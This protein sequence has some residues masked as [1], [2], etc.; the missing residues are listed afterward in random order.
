MFVCVCIYIK[1]NSSVLHSNTSPRRF[2]IIVS[3]YSVQPFGGE[4]KKEK[5]GNTL[6]RTFIFTSAAPTLRGNLNIHYKDCVRCTYVG[7]CKLGLG[8]SCVGAGANVVTVQLKENMH[9]EKKCF[10]ERI[11]K[12]T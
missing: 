9:V 11:P 6:P 5:K 7:V 1:I 4:T 2:H 3:N 12:Q 10:G 8:L